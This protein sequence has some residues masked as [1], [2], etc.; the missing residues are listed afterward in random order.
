MSDFN[1]TIYNLKNKEIYL[2]SDFDIMDF[3]I[4]KNYN[5]NIC[6]VDYNIQVELSADYFKFREQAGYLQSFLGGDKTFIF[7]WNYKSI[8][9]YF[10]GKSKFDFSLNGIIIDLYFLESYLGFKHKNKPKS[11]LEFKSRLKEI[12]NDE[13]FK[14]AIL[15]HNQIYL[16]SVNVISSIE[17]CGLIYKNKK[18]LVYSNYEIDGQVNGRSICSKGYK[19][20]INPHCLTTEDKENLKIPFFDG[21]FISFDY[22]NMEVFMLQWLSK[23]PFMDELLNNSNDFYES[24]WN[25]LI[26]KV[27]CNS[28]HRKT[29]KEF[30]LPV[31]YGL[32]AEALSKKINW[33]INHAKKIVEDINR[34]F[35]VSI[36]WMNNQQNK[37]TTAVD[38]F[39]RRRNFDNSY[40]IRNFIVQSP[41]SLVCM[42]KLNKLYVNLSDISKICMHIHDGYIIISD[43][44]KIEKTIQISKNILEQDSDMYKGLNLKTVCSVGDS[45][46]N[47]NKQL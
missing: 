44:N 41:A 32:G 8:V 46:L 29:C 40:L 10:K 37:L 5:I 2:Y 7:T 42:D 36:S 4:D 20:S 23:D 9:S 38:Y 43:K 3:T 24:V 27:P 45:L 19:K 12:S 6:S 31:F 18:E 33:P 47:M 17:S 35:H 26:P 15:I 13:L 25:I 11:L 16:N 22:R 21:K 30:F 34:L 28:N 39:G 1:T 14:N